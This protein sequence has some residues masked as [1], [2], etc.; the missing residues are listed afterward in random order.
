MRRATDTS[1]RARARLIVDKGAYCGEGGFL[2]QMAA[3]HACGPYQIDNVFAVESYLNY[4]N[5]QPWARSEAQPPRRCVGGSEQHMDEVARG[6][7]LDPVELRRRTVIEKGAEGPTRQ[8]FDEVGIERTL[9]RAVEMIGYDR[10]LPEDEAIGVAVGWWP[11]M[12]AAS[13]PTST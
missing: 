13:G 4:T 7:R 6:A 2:G 11:C 5:H 12:P 8:I 9:E 1:W 10:E 3:M